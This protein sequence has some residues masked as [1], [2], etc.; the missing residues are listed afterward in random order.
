MIDCTTCKEWKIETEFAKDSTTTRGYRYECKTCRLTKSR[1]YARKAY[2]KKR[3]HDRETKEQRERLCSVHS[4]AHRLWLG[5]PVA[6]SES[7]QRAA[8]RE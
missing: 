5:L 2:Y 1:A 7:A 6:P 3:D 4:P 8:D